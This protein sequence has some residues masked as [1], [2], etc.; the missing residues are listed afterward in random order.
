MGVD[1]MAGGGGVARLFGGGAR[2]KVS[3]IPKKDTRVQKRVGGAEV[4]EDS[5]V[6]VWDERKGRG[7]V[8][9]R[10]HVLILPDRQSVVGLSAS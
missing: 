10:R 5:R 1:A 9:C 8:P 7:E 6:V 2:E 3:G 4:E